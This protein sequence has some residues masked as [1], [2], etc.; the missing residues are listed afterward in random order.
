MRTAR[1]RA[2][3]ANTLRLA[4]EKGL[5]S[6]AFAAI[7]TD[8]FGFQRCAK[9]MFTGTVEY[10]RGLSSTLG[11]VVFCLYDEETQA[12]LDGMLREILQG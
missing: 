4:E 3:T 1:L 7:S 10:L 9:V 8:V 2:A 5:R 11:K 6:M 12:I